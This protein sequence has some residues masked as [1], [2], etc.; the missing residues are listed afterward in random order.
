MLVSTYVS[1]A[2]LLGNILS[3]ESGDKC[4]LSLYSSKLQD[5]EAN[6]INNMNPGIQYCAD[7]A[8]IF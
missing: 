7:E 5:K 4:M 6:C 8:V 3:P 1:G 2:M